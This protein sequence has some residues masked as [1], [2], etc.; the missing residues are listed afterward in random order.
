MIDG[1]ESAQLSINVV[2]DSC[3]V[4]RCQREVGARRRGSTLHSTL[5]VRPHH[6]YFRHARSNVEYLPIGSEFGLRLL[7]RLENNLVLGVEF[8]SRH[9]EP[10]PV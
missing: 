6:A 8:Q 2:K 5:H 10:L 3:K 7:R 9:H 1:E 4:I